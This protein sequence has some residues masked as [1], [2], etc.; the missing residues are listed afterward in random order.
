ML[1]KMSNGRAHLI[2]SGRVQG[3]FFRAFTERTAITHNLTGWVRN[4]PGGEVEAV[5]EGERQGIES[6]IRQCHLGP[7]SSKVYN[8]DVRWEEFTGEYKGF[9]IRYY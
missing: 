2:I 4:M 5:F 3:V 1:P 6:A 9:S 7:P 8:I